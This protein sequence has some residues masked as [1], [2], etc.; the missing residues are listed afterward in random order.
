MRL[1]EGDAR[2]SDGSENRN[3]RCW[4]FA[5]IV[6]VQKQKDSN[7][8]AS[9]LGPRFLGED[10]YCYRNGKFNGKSIVLL[11]V[12]AIVGRFAFPG[13]R[14]MRIPSTISVY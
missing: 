14:I 5:L 8:L 9:I 13:C 11:M 6:I 1:I 4:V 2:S 7:V 3:A 12:A 10:P